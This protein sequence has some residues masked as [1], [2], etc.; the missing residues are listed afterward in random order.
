MSYTQK[1]QFI[2]L[3][4]R[5]EILESVGFFLSFR[6]FAFFFSFLLD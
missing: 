4:K 2:Q 1:L 5:V 6:Y 3:N